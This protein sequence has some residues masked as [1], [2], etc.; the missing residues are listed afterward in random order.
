MPVQ[1]RLPGRVDLGEETECTAG[2]GNRVQF[3]QYP[4]SGLLQFA[5]FGRGCVG[6][7][8]PAERVGHDV[9]RHHS[10]DMVHQEERTAQQFPGGLD[11][12]HLRHRDLGECRNQPQHLV[13]V[14]HPVGGEHRDVSRGRRDPGHPLPLDRC[15][16]L[17]PAAGQDDALR[18]HAV[19]VDTA[20]DF[21]L[22]FDWGGHDGG[23]PLRQGGG[24]ATG[25][26]TRAL[27][28]VNVG[29]DARL[30]GHIV[31]RSLRYAPAAIRNPRTDPGPDADQ[32]VR[33]PVAE[34][35]RSSTGCGSTPRRNVISAV[36][37]IAAMVSAPGGATCGAPCGA[38]VKNI[39]TITRT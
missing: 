16:V 25:V 37:P 34:S 32:D 12:A 35:A 10:L 15:T 26:T 5:L 9:R 24:K 30:V 21:H 7:P 13:L 1:C 22:G 6:E 18:G 29:L 39:S 3:G 33:N 36:T 27:Q 23:Q 17:G 31:L 14:V 4:D 11:P 28:S 20:F 2:I 19:G 8:V 38:S